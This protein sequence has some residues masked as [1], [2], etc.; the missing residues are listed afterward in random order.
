MKK[1]TYKQ[2][3]HFIKSYAVVSLAGVLNAISLFSFI[4]PVNLIAGGFSGLAS[5]LSHVFVLFLDVEFEQLMSVV[6]FVLNIPLLICSLIFLR[7]DFTFKTIWATLVSSV[8]L[9]ILPKDLQ[10]NSSP[11]I[12]VIFGGLIIGVA[13]FIA[14]EENGS[15]G[16]T[17]VIGRIVNKYHPEVDI[18]RVILLCNFFITLSGSIVT[19]VVVPEAQVDIILYSFIYV[20]IGGNVLGMLRRGFNHPQKFLIVTTE[21]EKIGQDIT[22]Q[23]QRGYT[24]F[25]L[26]NSY[27]GRTRKMLSVVVQYRQMNILKLLVRKRDPHAF[28]IIKDVSDVFSRPTFN[29]NY[30]T[31]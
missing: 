22:R 21:Y 17:E 7:G 15:N 28:T 5:T 30:K 27:D 10:F 20:L 3:L 29:R 18:S 9:G 2:V 6:Y 8:V 24:T 23:F 25:D 11:I 1:I 16:G 31:K 13:M 26:E 19:V 14:Y 4:N 12:C